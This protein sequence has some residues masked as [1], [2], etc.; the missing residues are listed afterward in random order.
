MTTQAHDNPPEDLDPDEQDPQSPPVV[1]RDAYEALEKDLKAERKQR[2]ALEERVSTF[3]AQAR[4]RTLTELGFAERDDD[5]A[6]KLTPVGEAVVKL[7]E[8][9]FTAEA[10]RQTAETYGLA[11]TPAQDETV[12][13]AAREAQLG[14]LGT[15]VEPQ[16]ADARYAKAEAEGDL[17]GMVAAQNEKAREFY[18][19]VGRS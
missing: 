16:T 13:E 15:P 3:E 11:Q 6:V 7:H 9:E 17:E 4:E 14:A 12:T 18:A 8:G 2:Q 10:V 1:P 5:G 19:R